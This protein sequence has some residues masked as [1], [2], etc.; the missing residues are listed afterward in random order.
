MGPHIVTASLLT[1]LWATVACPPAVF[2]DRMG[3]W[4]EKGDLEA[5]IEKGE[6]KLARCSEGDDTTSLETLLQTAWLQRARE[7]RTIEAM[8]AVRERFPG[9]ATAQE[10]LGVEMDLDWS[11]TVQR[12]TVET[13][14][15]HQKRYPG[16]PHAADAARY[17]RQL[18]LDRVAASPSIEAWEQFRQRFPERPASPETVNREG[19]IAFMVTERRGSATAWMAYLEEYGQHSRA[20]EAKERQEKAA[21][22]ESLAVPGTEALVAYLASHEGGAH[23]P[24][25]RWALV[26]GTCQ[27]L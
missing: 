4:I 14:A 2:L 12:N 1:V 22:E 3:K 10:A 13:Y 5:A 24:H 21:F 25:A 16:S 6:E 15:D 17:E 8:A 23:N 19:E 26:T 20:A 27:R 11:D 7:Q 9:T 18:A